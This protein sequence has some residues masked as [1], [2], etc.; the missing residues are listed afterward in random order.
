[1]S[2]LSENLKFLRKKNKISQDEFA[3]LLGVSQTSIAHYER[4]SR[5][6]TIDTLIKIARHYRISI[7]E[8][9][10]NIKTNQPLEKSDISIDTLYDELVKKNEKA[11]NKSIWELSR[12]VSMQQLLEDYLK[13]L[14]YRIGDDWEKGLISE[15][16]EHY[17]THLIRRTLNGI[18]AKF[19]R[20]INHKRAIT[21][22][23]HSEQHTLGIEMV[24]AFLESN[25]IETL[26]L[27]TNLPIRSLQKLIKEYE[28]QYI[29]LSVTM[30]DHINSLMTILDVIH[31][32]NV[33]QIA[34]G[35]QGI[36]SG[37]EMIA[38]NYDVT[39]LKSMGHI[40]EFINEEKVG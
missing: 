11:F 2:K 6:P 26:Y 14:L 3:S 20:E 1:M 32:P 34:I 25:G 31:K 23:V 4:G 28:P 10:G 37:R 24:T 9:V 21:L 17:A 36:E 12:Q 27:G 29:F 5:Q 22:S 19:R 7:D 30:K 33:Y 8:L 16:D 38:M 15:A 18:S 35:G 40:L 39:I 13:L